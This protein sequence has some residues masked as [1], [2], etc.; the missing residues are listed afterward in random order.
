MSVYISLGQI[1]PGIPGDVSRQDGLQVEPA[2]FKEDNDVM[3]G[4]AV[5]FDST[6]K[7][8]YFADDGKAFIGLTTRSYPQGSSYPESTAI[9]A[10]RAVGLMRRGYM[11]VKCTNGNPVRGG[12]VYMYKTAN[13]G[14]EVGDFSAVED[15]SY[16][17][18]LTGIEWAADGVINNC[19]EVLM[20]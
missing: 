18:E 16:T 19:A 15:S 13:G 1:S 10:G 6:G 12:K 20:L 14:H 9:P 17:V 5:A 3:P 4:R 11:I 2:F 8:V 7:L